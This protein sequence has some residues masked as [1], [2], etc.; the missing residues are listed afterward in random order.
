MTQSFSVEKF[1]S[2]LYQG[3]WSNDLGERV[4]FKARK[5]FQ[6]KDSLRGMLEVVLEAY[7]ESLTL[8]FGSANFT[9]ANSRTS[10]AKSLQ[11]AAPSSIDIPWHDLVNAFAN[12]VVRLYFTP[13]KPVKLSRATVSER[14]F[15][16]YPILPE[17]Y[18]SLIFAPGGSGKSLLAVFISMLVQNGYDI[19]FQPTGKKY[20]V[21]YLDWEMDQN[22]IARRCSMFDITQ[23]L[24][25]PYYMQCYLPL[26]AMIDDLLDIVTRE[27]IKLV[28]IDSAAPALGN[29][30]NDST[31]VV[32]LFD[33]VR[34]LN[35]IGV[36]V[37]V[38]TH[39]SK[40][41]KEKEDG[42]MPIGSVYFENLSRLAWELKYRS[43]D[44]I[45]DVALLCRKT[46]F[47]KLPPVG[48]R[49][50]FD[51]GFIAVNKLADPE[52][53]GTTVETTQEEA[54]LSVLATGPASAD[55][56][57]KE[58]GIRSDRVWTLLARL[59]KEGVVEQIE[60]GKWKLNSKFLS[61][62]S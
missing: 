28:V 37:L 21:M 30:I 14:S 59:K 25:Y 31:S 26:N 29:D 23:D 7:G 41:H 16:L 17:G 18:P 12:K 4:I 52:T 39:V 42:A 5:V 10:L 44:R 38:L 54:I 20:N 50:V 48:F 60:R 36:T 46:N 2:G 33:A 8:Y 13:P 35:V 62:A 6:E 3:I 58:I 57:A 27:N 22:E 47:G 11:Q 55:E 61:K 1:P 24:E 51:E 53:V 15:L 43:G 9:G 32:K 19:N 40:A 49:F 56:I 45:M 34:M